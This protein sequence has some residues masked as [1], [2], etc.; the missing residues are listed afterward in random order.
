MRITFILPATGL[1]GGAKAVFEFANHLHDRN[2]DVSVIYPLLPL[3]MSLARWYNPRVLKHRAQE[4]IA[5]LKQ[6]VH[7]D[8]FNLKAKLIRVPILAEKYIPNSDII[9]ATWWET[10]YYVSRYNNRKGKK[11][12][13]AQHYEIWG[14]PKEKVDKSYRLGLKIIVNSTWL[15][16]ILENELKVKVER[17]ILHAPDRDDFYFEDRDRGEGAVKILIPFRNTAWKGDKDGIRAFEIAKKEHPEIKLVMFGPVINKDVPPYAEFYLNPSAAKLREIYNSSDIFVFPSLS[18]GFGMPPLEAMACK[19][20][21]VLTN[22]GA[23]SEYAIP[24]KTA[25]VSSPGDPEALA[26][27]IIRLI[28]DKQLRKEIAENGYNYTKHFTWEK[29]TEE[30]E[31]VFQKYFS[32]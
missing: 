11:F 17:L 31:E 15:K 22:V 29:A 30:L 19:C 16:N 27:N 3:P 14:G 32:K 25:L 21:S 1:S 28:E 12:Y 7:I 6:G 23:V 10:A 13:L 4:I 24:E 26:R 18:E 9:I 20:A 5:N 8:W 2:H